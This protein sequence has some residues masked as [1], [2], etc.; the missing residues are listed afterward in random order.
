MAFDFA[1]A[2]AG[3]YA[4]SRLEDRRG[5]LVRDHYSDHKA[6]FSACVTETGCMAHARRKFHELYASNQSQIAEEALKLFGLLYDIKRTPWAWTP[7]SGINSDNRRNQ[8][9]IC[10]LL[11]RRHRDCYGILR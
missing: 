2:R 4:C 7:T 11:S 3:E 5:T 1:E 9:S 6:L 8:L 10:R